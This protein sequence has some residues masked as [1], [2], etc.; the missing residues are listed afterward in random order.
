[1]DTWRYIFGQNVMTQKMMAREAAS[2]SG[3]MESGT[4]EAINRD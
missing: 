4:K 2:P 3:G 1:M